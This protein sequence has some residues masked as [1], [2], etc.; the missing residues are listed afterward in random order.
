MLGSVYIH[1]THQLHWLNKSGWRECIV[2]LKKMN[3]VVEE[4]E[5]S[6][7]KYLGFTDPLVGVHRSLEFLDEAKIYS[8][9]CVF[10]GERCLT[11]SN[12]WTENVGDD[13][14]SSEANLRNQKMLESI[15]VEVGRR[16]EDEML[17]QPVQNQTEHAYEK[18]ALKMKL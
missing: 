5:S 10:N 15:N 13:T 16:L 18:M 6:G 4:D 1:R 8:R 7:C 2:R 17:H 3:H 14:T 9:L 12:K 11:A